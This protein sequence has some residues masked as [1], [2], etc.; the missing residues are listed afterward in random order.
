MEIMTIVGNVFIILGALIFATAA[1]GILRFPDAY[2]RIS[3]VGTAGGLGICL[4]VAGAF[5]HMPTAVD[6]VQVFLIIA[7]QLA[8]SAVGTM[9]IA[10]STYLRGVKMWRPHFNDLEPESVEENDGDSPPPS[11]RT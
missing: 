4:V 9:A 11:P 5:W 3:A 2:T 10:R 6:A 7:L 8:T 1:L